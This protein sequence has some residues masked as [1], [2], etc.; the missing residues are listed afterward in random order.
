[1]G[2]NGCSKMDENKRVLEDVSSCGT[3]VGIDAHQSGC[4]CE[5]RGT[6]GL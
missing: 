2:E 6:V 3:T 1:M 4:D 5:G